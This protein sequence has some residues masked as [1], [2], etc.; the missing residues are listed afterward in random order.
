MLKCYGLRGIS[1]ILPHIFEEMFGSFSTR[2][3]SLPQRFYSYD[4][5]KTQYC[6]VNILLVFYNYQEINPPDIEFPYYIDWNVPII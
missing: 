3:L 4:V 5:N 1:V 2:F 6:I